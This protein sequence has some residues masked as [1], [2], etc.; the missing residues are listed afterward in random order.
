MGKNLFR[1]NEVTFSKERV[2]ISPPELMVRQQYTAQQQALARDAEQYKGPTAEDLRK[3]AEIFKARWDQE[4]EQMIES[5]KAEAEK[6]IQGA[7]NHAFEEVKKKNDSA[8]KV[9]IEA[10]ND[11]REILEKARREAEE[12]VEKART[13]GTELKETLRKEGYNEGIDKGYATGTEEVQRIV[14]RIHVVLTKA[15]E[16]R[17]EII[18]ESEG[19]LVQLVL[20]IATKVVKV[21][22]ENQ[23]N[24]VVNNVVQ[25]LRKLK[26]KADVIIRVNLSDLKITTEHTKELIEKFERV[27]SITVMEDSTVDPGGCIIE[28][29]F[30][31]I[32]A[33]ISSQLREIEEKILELTP[34]SSKIKPVSGTGL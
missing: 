1:S 2:H 8:L 21:L 13:E 29:D 15:I 3:E 24:I 12:I 18:S 25:A 32:D 11:A 31:Q 17:N 6:I 9:K 19:Q 22:S 26:S 5:A 7:E 4:R 14:E 28:T 34:I 30:G 27:N 16:R 33:R 23:K 10:E 20:Q